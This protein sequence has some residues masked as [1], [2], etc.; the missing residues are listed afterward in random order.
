[1]RAIERPSF[2]AK[3]GQMAVI[4]SIFRDRE[5]CVDDPAEVLARP[6]APVR[7]QRLRRAHLRN[8]LVPA[9]PA[10]RSAR[11]P[12]RSASC[13]ARSW[14]ACASAASC[15]RASDRARPASA[16]RLRAARAGH[17]RSSA[18]SCCS[19]CRSS[20]ASTR[21]GPAPG[22][23]GI[24]AARRRRRH[25]PAAA[26][27]ADG[28]DAAGD[29]ALGRGD[30]GRRL[31][32]RLL[33]RRQHRRRAWSAA[34]SPGFYLLRVYDMAIATLR[35]GGA[36]RRRRA[37]SRLLIAR[38]T[39]AR[40]TTR[41]STTPRR[42]RRRGCDWAV[43]VA[44]ALSGLTALG[45]EVIW[46]RLLSLLFGATRLHV[47]ADPRRLPRRPRHR[48]QRSGR[49]IGARRERPRVALGWCQLLLVRR[50]RVG[51]VHADASRCRTGRS[52]RRSRP[53]PWFNFQLDLVRCLWV[54]A[55]GARSSGAR[56][57]RWRWRRSRRAARIRRGWSAASTRPTPSARSS[58]SLAASLVLVVVDR[59]PARAAG[60]DRRRRRCRGC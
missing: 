57:F 60:A 3:S 31:V 37:R 44:I 23:A 7:R 6:A 30:A 41:A 16:A 45:A 52:T 56:A 15:C 5:R 50:D 9:P 42:R 55:A 19:A 27:A 32:A 59:Q 28:R 4:P 34:C 25:L 33:L 46:T 24:S 17:R 1:M 54:G 39:P 35:R 21:R 22:V 29:R 36:Q 18:C 13:S 26:D 53:T 58:G 43:Y 51:G 8:R 14:A 12:S 2:A 48:Q 47:L 38:A 49:R 40:V 11:R 10:R 20:A